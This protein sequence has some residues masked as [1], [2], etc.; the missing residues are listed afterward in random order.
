[1]VRSRF[2]FFILNHMVE[3]RPIDD[4]PSDAP[5][6]FAAVLPEDEPPKQRESDDI[7][8]GEFED[9]FEDEF[10]SDEEVIE[11]AGSDAG[12]SLLLILI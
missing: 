12:V 8:M 7:E 9:P 10:E 3:K 6:K 1:M 4:T 11:N 2:E 5:K